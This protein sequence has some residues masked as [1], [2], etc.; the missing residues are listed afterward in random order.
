[1]T[2]LFSVGALTT[3][4]TGWENAAIRSGC[5]TSGSLLD[6]IRVTL[7][8]HSS[9]NTKFDNVS[10]GADA[11]GN[12]D[13]DCVATPDELL[14]S[15]ASGVTI[16]AG[17]DST[18]D[19]TTIVNTTSNPS[20][21]LNVCMDYSG[22]L[23]N[24]RYAAGSRTRFNFSDNSYNVAAWTPNGSFFART[25]HCISV[26]TQSVSTTRGGKRFTLLGAGAP[27]RLR[28]AAPNVQ[29][30]TRETLWQPSRYLE[31]RP[32]LIFPGF[33]LP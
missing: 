23:G 20:N 30:Y 1:M 6:Q 3:N 10:I 2:T 25:T 4:D 31:A 19:W 21:Q 27:M 24:M 28:M 13:L 15:G 16:T 8:A 33:R 12:D 11:S 29:T 14:W 22:T 17:M 26:E 18:S 5:G 7:S 32:R 9:S